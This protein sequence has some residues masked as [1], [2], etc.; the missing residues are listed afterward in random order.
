MRS[1]CGTVHIHRDRITA[2][3]ADEII[4]TAP[5]IKGILTLGAVTRA[6]R[7]TYVIDDTENVQAHGRK[8]FRGKNPLSSIPAVS[9]P[10]VS[11]LIR[12]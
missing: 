10:A 3:S 11:L 4:A 1:E 6:G 7:Q 8:R 5:S 9:A 2:A 12:V